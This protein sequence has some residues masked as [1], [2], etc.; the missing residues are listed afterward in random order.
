[1]VLD[2]LHVLGVCNVTLNLDLAILTPYGLALGHL[3]CGAKHW[4]RYTRI[5]T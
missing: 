4:H 1:M 5:A 2:D 3:R